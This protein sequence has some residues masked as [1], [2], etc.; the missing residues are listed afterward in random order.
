MKPKDLTAGEIK[1]NLGATWVPTDDVEQFIS[2]TFN[3][4][5]KV[6]FS[7]ASGEWKIDDASK[8]DGTAVL[9]DTYG[10]ERLNAVELL[11]R[12]LNHKMIKILDED[13]H[14]LVEETILARRKAEEIKRAFSDWVFKDDERKE[15]LVNYYNR[16]FNNIV[17]RHFDGSNL[18]F[19]GMSADIELKPHQKNAVARTLYGGNTLLAHV[20][21]AGKT[22]EMQASCM[23]AKRLGLSHKAAMIMPGHLTA[24]FGHEFRRLYPNAKILVADATD[25]SN[26][27][28]N[29]EKRRMFLAKIASQDWDAV[30]MNYQQFMSIPLSSER[31]MSYIQ[32][33]LDA[34]RDFLLSVDENDDEAK[35]SVKEAEKMARKLEVKMETLREKLAANQD[36][37]GMTFENLGIDRLY[38]DESHYYKNLGFVTKMS[39][40]PHANK[41]KTDDSANCIS[42]SVT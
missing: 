12:A 6:Y 21:G 29:R 22:F 30:I 39:G 36:D 23:E 26:G 40:I 33:D 9:T 25:L 14:E 3:V 42:F 4:Y 5:A 19:P 16:H 41:E 37:F 17:P 7:S 24:Q 32:Q 8:F 31:Q 28:E 38:V 34:Y 11:E 35:Y 1:V 20:V 10:T 13:K 18:T 15:R 2:D 27:E